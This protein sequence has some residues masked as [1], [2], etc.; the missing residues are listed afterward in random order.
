MT[1]LWSRYRQQISLWS[2]Y[3]K[4]GSTNGFVE[5]LDSAKSRLLSK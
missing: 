5:C 3:L 2:V 4:M 1:I